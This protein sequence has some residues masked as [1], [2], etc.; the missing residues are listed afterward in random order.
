MSEHTFLN[1]QQQSLSNSRVA[2]AAANGA[3]R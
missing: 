3:A 2:S 1:A